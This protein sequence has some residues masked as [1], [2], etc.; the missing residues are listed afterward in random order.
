MLGSYSKKRWLVISISI[1]VTIILFLLVGNT[2]YRFVSRPVFISGGIGD[3]E[4]IN[5]DVVGMP[6][7]LK[8][9]LASL[10][11][12]EERA[13]PEM[14]IPE[15]TKTSIQ[16]DSLVSK[17]KDAVQE[18]QNY[19]AKI[20]IIKGL[21]AQKGV[22]GGTSMNSTGSGGGSS[23][24][25]QA[26]PYFHTV[27]QY[28]RNYWKIP[29]WMKTDGLNVLVMMKIADDGNISEADI[30]QS[31]GNPD[32]DALALNAVR[33]AAPFPTPPVSVRETVHSGIILSFP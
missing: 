8:K 21:Q 13:K 32:F 22:A 2:I 11:N 28:V 20:K 33:N 7:I 18:E 1:H 30:S 25:V 15:K 3:G 31:S 27:K 14:T 29:N 26:N 12:E 10:N 19:L 24:A 17:I 16:K 9:D 23:E 4:P 6:N 5:I